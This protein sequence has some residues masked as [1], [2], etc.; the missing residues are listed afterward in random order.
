MNFC[1]MCHRPTTNEGLCNDCK[2][3]EQQLQAAKIQ[4]KKVLTILEHGEYY[5]YLVYQ[6]KTFF[7]EI[8][9]GIIWAP[10]QNSKGQTFHHWTRLKDLK[11]GDRIFHCVNGKIEAISTV[12]KEAIIRQFPD[13]VLD[14]EKYEGEGRCVEC[15]YVRYHK[16]L[17]LFYY[18]D[19]TKELGQYKYSPFNKDGYGIQGYLFPLCDKLAELFDKEI[20]E[21]NC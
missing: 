1:K 18:R 16:P 10:I 6:G 20:H 11:I 7:T 3:K 8:Y 19:K 14:N 21:F 4:A 2:R 13:K 9:H 17:E 5:N 15:N 12:T